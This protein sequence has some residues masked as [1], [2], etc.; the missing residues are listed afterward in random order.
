MAEFTS[1]DQAMVDQVKLEK[2]LGRFAKKSNPEIKVFV[3]RVQENIAAATKRKSEQVNS[4]AGDSPVPARTAPGNVVG[5]VKIASQLAGNK[6]PREELA[7]PPAKKAIRE[8]SKPLALQ[9]IEAR[10]AEL[11]AA[12]LAAATNGAKPATELKT[13]DSKLAD[14]KPKPV[15][16]PAPP[17]KP[18]SSVFAN[19]MSASKKP[20]TSN[21]ARAA[22][23]KEKAATTASTVPTAAVKTEPS[24]PVSLAASTTSSSRPTF[25]FS[26]MLAGLNT[27]KVVEEKV[28]DDQRDETEEEKAKRLRKEARR[29][30][31]VTWKPD[32]VLTEI[33]IFSHHPDEE[34][35]HGDSTTRDM[36]D[37]SG[38]GR[39]LKMHKDLDDMDED[40]EIRAAGEDLSPFNPPS[41]VVFEGID[42][43]DRE[44]NFVKRGGLKEAESAERAAQEQR[45]QTSL[46][47]VYTLPSDIPPSPKEPPQE[48]DD[49]YSPA[50]AF[51]E[52]TE[53]FL[54]DRQRKFYAA[55]RASNGA[56]ATTDLT[57]ILGALGQQQAPQPKPLTDLE[58]TFSMFAQP[59]QPQAQLSS[60]SGG[61]D[62]A[63]LLS[64]VQ[65]TQ[66]H[67]SAPPPP[68][69]PSIPAAGTAAPNNLAA[70]LAALQSQAPQ[71]KPQQQPQFPDFS[72]GLSQSG[73]QPIFSG[74][75]DSNSRKHELDD[76]DP[77]EERKKKTKALAAAG[78]AAAVAP[79]APV[80]TPPPTTVPTDTSSSGST[81]PPAGDAK[82]HPKA[83]TVPCRFFKEGK[84]KKGADCTYIH[85]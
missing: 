82:A 70:I 64:V 55:T 51:G 15:S 44:R 34:V 9:N 7:Q 32:E 39:M 81:P 36:D 18:P 73:N 72:Q 54:H 5:P 65:Q 50:I 67:H 3:Q 61:L 57:A 14:S 10:K 28:V 75:Q 12:K 71:P 49:D 60:M 29:K 45:E 26:S 59:Q 8:A 23:A 47:V 16:Q 80:S 41:E 46:M 76:Y 74:N 1:L 21:A 42:A 40:E 37:I 56:S 43:E 20:G 31:R 4:E 77:Y 6:R 52:P 66:H 22:A 58:R 24:L 33:R 69:A 19:L 85:D 27:P 35:G 48:A 17:V 53:P 25:S 63:K 62:L 2:P 83:K 84:C 30:L 38:E 13:G 11:K 68:A 78:A 79:V